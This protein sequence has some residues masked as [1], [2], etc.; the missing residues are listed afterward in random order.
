MKN[1]STQGVW[2]G[3]GPVVRWRMVATRSGEKIK[4]LGL[5]FTAVG[6]RPRR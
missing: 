4:Q 2:S 6:D 5:V 3:K 1:V